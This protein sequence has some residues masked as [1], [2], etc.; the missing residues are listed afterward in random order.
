MASPIILTGRN[1]ATAFRRYVDDITEDWLD[2]AEDANLLWGNEEVTQFMNDALAEYHRRRQVRANTIPQST[3][4]VTGDPIPTHY[5][6]NYAVS[7]GATQVLID[8]RIYA[9]LSARLD[10][11]LLQKLIAAP[12]ELED[13]PRSPTCYFAEENILYFNTRAVGLGLL[14]LK[15]N[16]FPYSNIQSVTDVANLDCLPWDTPALM[17][18]MAFRAY[19]KNDADTLDLQRADRERLL[20]D[21]QIGQRVSS[22]LE[23]QRQEELQGQHILRTQSYE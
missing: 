18:W 15:V 5:L 7:P 2:S 9:V 12:E 11:E 10:D 23:R 16:R 20:F 14:T 4:P 8:P 6:V 22:R 3:D 17:H 1:L 21:E 13:T 19:S